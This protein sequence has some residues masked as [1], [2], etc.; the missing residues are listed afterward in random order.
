MPYRK[1]T[2]INSSAAAKKCAKFVALVTHYIIK[3]LL[4]IY[5][6]K[7]MD[8]LDFV[9]PATLNKAIKLDPF[10]NLLFYLLQCQCDVNTLTKK[11]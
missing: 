9:L 6:K 1:L 3:D 10:L 5:C 4:W 7:K 11:K 8:W 2:S